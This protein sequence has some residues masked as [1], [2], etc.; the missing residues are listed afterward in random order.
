MAGDW[1]KVEAVTPDKPEVWAIASDLG[2][3]PD[4]AFGKLFRVWS[5]FDSHTEDGNASSVT[6]AL[7]D[8]Q[9]G[10]TGFCDAVVRAGWMVDDGSTLSLPNFENHNGKTAKSRALTAKRVA[11]HK[12]KGNGKGNAESVSDALPREEKRRSSTPCSPP[13]DELPPWKTKRF[14][15]QVIAKYHEHCPE[16]PAVRVEFWKG[17]RQKNLNARLAEYEPARELGWWDK[18]F[19]YVAAIDLLMG[20]LPPKPGQQDS[21]NADLGWLVKPENFRKVVENTYTQRGAA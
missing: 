11:E 5:W 12:R 10:V 8:R 13:K 7:L 1:L 2:I 15:E 21:W 14:H 17:E 16:L 3:D 20:R 9:V 18:F 4:A 19:G 6:K